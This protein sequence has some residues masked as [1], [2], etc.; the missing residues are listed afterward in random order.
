MITERVKLLEIINRMLPGLDQKNLVGSMT[1]IH[2]Q[3]NGLVTYNDSI[4]IKAQFPTDFKCAVHGQTL[5]NLLKGLDT[6][7]VKLELV[8]NKLKINTVGVTANLNLAEGNEIDDI[9][10]AIDKEIKTL[11]TIE[12]LPEDFLKAVELCMWSAFVKDVGGSFTCIQIADHY[13]MSSDRIRFSVYEMS[14]LVS[15]MMFK[16]SVATSLIKYQLKLYAVT[17][18]WLHFFESKDGL[19][20]SVRKYSGE[21]PVQEILNMVRNKEGKATKITLPDELTQALSFLN[22]FTEG[23]EQKHAQITVKGGQLSVNVQGVKGSVTKKMKIESNQDIEFGINPALLQ[24][25]LRRGVKTIEVK[26]VE[27]KIPMAFFRSKNFTHAIALF[28]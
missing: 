16:A 4:F 27:G 21:Y 23:Q 2:F 25:I 17:R 26:S 13:M 12:R 9:L 1:M 18:S 20:F 11:K 28:E 7:K 24:E 15:E 19:I 8:D 14:E 3:G 22:V 10:N 6:E 5:Y